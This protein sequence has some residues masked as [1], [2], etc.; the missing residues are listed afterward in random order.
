MCVSKERQ[1]IGENSSAAGHA[2]AEAT[3]FVGSDLPRRDLVA[4]RRRRCAAWAMLLTVVGAASATP[5]PEPVCGR[6]LT[7]DKRGVI[8][9]YLEGDGKL[10]GRL[11]GGPAPNENDVKNPDPALRGRS[12]LGIKLMQGF[13]RKD[14]GVWREG[15]IYDGDSGK[16][17]KANVRLRDPDA[18]RLLLRG[19][20]GIPLLGRTAEW[21]REAPLAS[22]ACIDPLPLRENR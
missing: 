15:S 8:H 14:D 13:V 6:W 18:N 2:L 22:D 20:V 4:S 21:T 1:S 11:V 10:A 3:S 19:Y 12:L 16:L 5:R 17:Y 7:E 9:V